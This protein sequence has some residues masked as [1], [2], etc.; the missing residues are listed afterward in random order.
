MT[1]L[2]YNV[3]SGRTERGSEHYGSLENGM[4][5]SALC[6]VRETLPSVGFWSM[7][8]SSPRRES[9]EKRAPMKSQKREHIRH[10]LGKVRG[11]GQELLVRSGKA[12]PSRSQGPFVISKGIWTLSCKNSGDME[13]WQTMR[14]HKQ[15]ETQ[16][17]DPARRMGI[18]IKSHT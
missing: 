16:G 4:T 8:R 3:V 5:N 17:K 18:G 12:I 13:G 6:V 7:T 2:K 11:L 14:W 15:F 10:A 9:T 1:P